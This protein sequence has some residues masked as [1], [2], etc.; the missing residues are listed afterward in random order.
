LMDCDCAHAGTLAEEA[1]SPAVS[2]E[3]TIERRITLKMD[4]GTSWRFEQKQAKKL[5][6]PDT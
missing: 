6:K 5:R 3:P 1:I 2:T 4:T